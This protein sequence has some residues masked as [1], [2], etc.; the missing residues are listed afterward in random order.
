MLRAMQRHNQMLL[1]TIRSSFNLQQNVR[2][3]LSHQMNQLLQRLMTVEELLGQ[4]QQQMA[5]FRRLAGQPVGGGIGALPITAP[6]PGT[7]PGGDAETLYELGIQK[8]GEQSYA[9]ARIA[10][11]ELLRGHAAHPRAPDAQF[12]LAETY[13]LEG[14]HER[15]LSELERIPQQ[16]PAAARAPQALFRAGVIA[17]ERNDVARARRYY[18]Q[19]VQ[20]YGN[21]DERR[22]AEARLRTLPQR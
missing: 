2:G 5:E 3:D 9:S 14:N 18:T 16:W 19:V 10:F 20:A 17:Q 12:H 13:Y 8:I 6:P 22:Q 4:Q 1:D 7:A 15:A 21:S 11:E